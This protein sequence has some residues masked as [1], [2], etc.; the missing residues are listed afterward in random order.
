MRQLEDHT[1]PLDVIATRKSDAVDRLAVLRRKAGASVLE[2]KPFDHGIITALE[3]EIAIL[4]EAEGEAVRRD[5]E[6][7][8]D[9]IEAGRAAMR[10]TIE[11]SERKRLAALEKA[12]KAAHE[13]AAT[14]VEALGHADDICG[15]CAALGLHAAEI[16]RDGMRDRMSWRLA[17]AMRALIDFRHEF[18]QARFPEPQTRFGELWHEAES[19]VAVNDIKRAMSA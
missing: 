1:D 6:K 12:E 9:A 8:R 16:H 3:A 15:G 17:Y 7:Q 14:L 5:R 19:K 13:M 11:E 2:G 4:G 18:G 10:R